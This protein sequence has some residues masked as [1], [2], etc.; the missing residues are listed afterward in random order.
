MKPDPVPSWKLSAG[1]E[2]RILLSLSPPPLASPPSSSLSSPSCSPS[3][4]SSSLLLSLPTGQV[5]PLSKSRAPKNNT[6]LV[7]GWKE[8]CSAMA[9]W[10]EAIRV[11]SAHSAANSLPLPDLRMTSMLPKGLPPPVQ[12]TSAFASAQPSLPR[13]SA[14]RC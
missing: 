14:T 9:P 10:N 13:N 4:A 8:S 1:T 5:K 6:A 11:F 7:P 12:G 2:H 3:A